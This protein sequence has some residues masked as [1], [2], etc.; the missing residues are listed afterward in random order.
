MPGPES[1]PPEIAVIVPH[2]EDRRGSPGAS[3]R[4]PPRS[5][6]TSRRS[7]STTGRPPVWTDPDRPSRHPYRHRTRERSR[8][9]A[10]SRSGRDD[11]AGSRL[12][13]RRSRPRTGLAERVRAA[14]ARPG[15]L[16]GGRVYIFD[17]TPPPRSG[18]EAFERVFAFRQRDYIE[19]KGFRHRQSRHHACG[20]RGDGAARAGPLGG[21]G[22]VLPGAEEGLPARLRRPH[23]RFIP[24]AATTLPSSASGDA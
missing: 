21:H 7:S 5:A 8:R 16:T 15:T 19:R 3:R 14:A 24:P 10:Q 22:L 2:Y 20:L 13:R 11:G 17:E 1:Q 18:A 23:D 4:S 12:P 9:G 6:R